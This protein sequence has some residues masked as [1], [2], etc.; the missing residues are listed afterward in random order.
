MQFIFELSKEH[1]TLPIAEIKS[2]LDA[3]KIKYKI[4]EENEDAIII[5]TNT[6]KKQR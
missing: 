3:E 2:C 5:E 6:G 4:N 1:K